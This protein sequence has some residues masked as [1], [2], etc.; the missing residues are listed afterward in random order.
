MLIRFDWG[1]KNQ[2]ITI[3]V[4]R[5]NIGNGLDHNISITKY[6]CRE[7]LVVKLNFYLKK[8]LSRKNAQTII[9]LVI[10]NVM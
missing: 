6:N 1:R 3:Y 7:N 8:H 4:N 10:K 9:L 5:L 2:N